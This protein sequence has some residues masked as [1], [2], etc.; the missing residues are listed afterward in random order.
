M[1]SIMG[2]MEEINDLANEIKGVEPIENFHASIESSSKLYIYYCI[3][4]EETEKALD[5]DVDSTKG[6]AATRDE[7]GCP[8]EAEI[9]KVY[10]LSIQEDHAFNEWLKSNDLETDLLTALA[11]DAAADEC[12]AADYKRDCMRD[13]L[14][15]ENM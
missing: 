12:D 15:T 5:I 4:E 9:T 6:Y 1:T 10:G 3:G 14:I 7:P 8:D 13:D 2:D 11:E